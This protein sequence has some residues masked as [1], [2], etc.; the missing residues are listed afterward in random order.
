MNSFWRY[1]HDKCG[2]QVLEWLGGGLVVAA[3][4]LWV[5]FVDISAQT[6]RDRGRLTS[7]S[8]VSG[9]VFDMVDN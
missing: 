6:H 1:S 9:R 7:A 2:Q 5:A 4:G 8:E 3:I